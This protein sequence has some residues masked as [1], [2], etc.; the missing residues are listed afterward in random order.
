MIVFGMTDFKTDKKFIEFFLQV[1]VKAGVDPDAKNFGPPGSTPNDGIRFSLGD[2][3]REMIQ[4]TEH[5]KQF[6]LMAWDE[7]QEDYRAYVSKNQT[8]N[9]NLPYIGE[10]KN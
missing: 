6:Y 4:G 2:M 8:S 5:G 1:N 10:N 7:L 9:P 3:V